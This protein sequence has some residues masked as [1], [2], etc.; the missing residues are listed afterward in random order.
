MCFQQAFF[1]SLR[2]H[3]ASVAIK[4]QKFCC[5]DMKRPKGVIQPYEGCFAEKFL[6]KSSLAVAVG[7]GGPLSGSK[8]RK[9]GER[10]APVSC[11][12]C[13]SAAQQS[14]KAAAQ[15]QPQ[16]KAPPVAVEARS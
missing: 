14:G 6:Q 10:V 16:P 2:L 4:V 3:M 13:S 15:L 8:G 1:L 5:E 9:E 7:Q 11:C 12:C